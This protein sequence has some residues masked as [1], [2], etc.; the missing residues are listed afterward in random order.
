NLYDTTIVDVVPAGI[1]ISDVDVEY[2]PT[3]T[4]PPTATPSVSGQ[5]ITLDLGDVAR[6]AEVRTVTITYQGTVTDVPANGNGT[7]LENTATL[8]WN[9]VDGDA[10]PRTPIDD[11]ATVTVRE[12]NLT[13]TKRV[14]HPA[15]TPAAQNGIAVDA[16]GGFHYRVVVTNTGTSTAHD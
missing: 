11:D 2:G 9:G 1:E 7:T 5:T 4:T 15:T 16:G 10:S 3:W 13:I 8:S 6:A 12:P 14:D